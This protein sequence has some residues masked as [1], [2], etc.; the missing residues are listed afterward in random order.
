MTLLEIEDLKVFYRT[1]TGECQAV[2]GVSFAVEEDECLGVVGESG[3]GKSTVVKAILGILPPNGWVPAG[4]IRFKGR[5]ILSLNSTDLRRL[6][7]KEISL[8]SQSA[9]NALDPVYRVGD[10]V[11][12]SMLAHEKIGADEAR[13]R[14]ESL[15]ELVGLDSGRTREYPHQFSGGMR[16]RVMIAMALSLDPTLIL[17]D[18][19]TTGLD[20]ITQHSILQKMRDLRRELKKSMLLV[21]HNMAVVAENCNRMVVMY[22]GKVME[23]GP[24]EQV[25]RSSHNPYTLGL[26]NAFPS[27]REE[28]TLISI[29]GAPPTLV[30][31]PPGCRF[32]D[33]CPFQTDSCVQEEPPLVEVADGQFTACHERMR[34]EE[35]RELAKQRELWL[36]LSPA[37]GRDR[38]WLFESAAR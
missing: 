30:D 28:K 33:R 22:A 20:V 16:Q 1:S 5:D 12:E 21:T 36:A 6:R 3:C 8:I 34:I 32:H 29:P 37:R 38:K 17:A 13:R 11:I 7:W 19:P 14:T 23:I 10:Q 2:D 26:H 31:P 24:T 25:L 18:E 35:I 9:M 27:L 15:F 4:E